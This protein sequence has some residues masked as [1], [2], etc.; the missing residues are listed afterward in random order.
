MDGWMDGWMK[1]QHSNTPILQQ[2]VL[3][4]FECLLH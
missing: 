3:L 4:S 2:P 1:T